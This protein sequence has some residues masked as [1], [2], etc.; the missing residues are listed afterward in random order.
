MDSPVIRPETPTRRVDPFLMSVLKSRFEAV[1]REMT[2][3]VMRASRSAVIKNARDLSCAILT[4]DHRLVST[5]DALPIHV[6]S[7][8]LATRPITELFD[9]IAD[10]DIFL[11]NCP[12]TGGTHH[13]DLIMAMPI[14]FDGKPLFWAVA[15]SHHADTGAP[16]PS[17]YLPFAKNIYE[18]GI[19]FP[20]V[21]VVEQHRE[22]QDILRIGMM[23]NRVPDIWLGDVRAQI[24]A[25]R[26]GRRRLLELLEKYGRDT[27]VAFVEDWFD[28]GARRAIAEIAKLPKGKFSYEVRHDP[29]PGVAEGGIPVRITIDVDPEAGEITVDVRDNMDNVP[30]GL[31]LSEN[32]CT[33]SCRIGVFNNLDDGIP[34]NEG[35]KSRIKVLMRE[36]SVVGKPRYPVGTSVATTNVNDRL[37]IA[38]NCVFS[39]MGEPYGQAE[40]GSHLPAGIGV[41][42]GKDPFKDRQPYV[43]QVFIGYAG[44]GARHGYDGWLTYCGPANGGLIALDSVEVDESM[45]P[46]IIESR[47]V[48][49]D[50]QGIGE[51]EG[52]PAVGG[53]FY[54]VDHEMT[55]VYS[56]DG[57]TF[58]PRGVL[59]GGDAKA[60]RSAKRGADGKLVELPAFHEEACRAG[61]RIEFVA[62]GGGG[63]GDPTKRDVRRVAA[64][65]G[66]GWLTSKAARESYKVALVL[67]AEQGVWVVD[68]DATARLRAA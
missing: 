61:E 45:Y 19:H 40:S 16:T 37:I 44:G 34:H 21:R 4:Y 36:G 29:V 68:Q 56:A 51:F 57:T 30:G 11:N 39:T 32:T 3:V 64:S 46:I 48:V 7:M 23:R 12:Y 15:L 25:C 31:N 59:G 65:V 22:K 28:Y 52:A 47:G 5:E 26:T 60:S 10:G 14:F 27:L 50:T 2:L 66:R 33:G 18:E 8:D 1:V 35:A 58:P 53:V 20:C 55:L 17:T 43:N 24:G 41:I 13:A 67:D 63:Y 62:C 6:M 38:G 42:S 9:D 49:A 54:P